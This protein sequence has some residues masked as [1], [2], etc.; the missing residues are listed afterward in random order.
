MKSMSRIWTVFVVGVALGVTLSWVTPVKAGPLSITEFSW[1]DFSDIYLGAPVPDAPPFIDYFDFAPATEG[2]D[3][4]VISAVFYGK[5]PASG[6][7]V[8]LYQLKI[9]PTSSSGFISG[10]AFDFLTTIPPAKVNN[11][12]VFTISD[13]DI[14]F[15]K[16]NPNSKPSAVVWSLSTPT[17]SQL[18]TNLL[19]WRDDQ[20]TT[21][22]PPD[23]EDP[24]FEEQVSYLWGF[25][26]PL[27]PTKIGAN[28]KDGGGDLRN[29]LVYTPSPEPSVIVLMSL[30]MLGLLGIKRRYFY[31]S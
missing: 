9:Y 17:T 20:D 19:L 11:V 29:P 15:G 23:D 26:H 27:P 31:N 25:F 8:Y 13:P 28:P 3:G 5:G 22:D 2:F 16:A 24:P 21:Q 18:S 4:E 12:E 30:G 1:A 14:L 7:Y 6:L 10:I